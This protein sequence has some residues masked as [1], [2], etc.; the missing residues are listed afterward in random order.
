MRKSTLL[1]A[2][3]AALVLFLSFSFMQAYSANVRLNAGDNQLKIK[4]NTYQD[5]NLTYQFSGFN[6]VDI[7]TEKGI[8]TRLTVPAYAKRGEFGSPELP[9]KS[10]LIEIPFNASVKITL[11]NV[12]MKEYSL[13]ELGLIHPVF[14]FQPPVP[15]TGQ[16]VPFVYNDAA[17]KVNSFGTSQPVSVEVL[18]IMRGVRIGRLDISPVQ[19]NPA[20]RTI[21]VYESMDVEISFE[22]ADIAKTLAQKHTYANFLFNPVY[23]SLINYKTEEN[24]GRDA[25]S[26]YPI[27]YVIISDRMFEAQLQPLIEWKIRKGFTVVEAYTDEPNVGTTS[28]QI[29]SFLQDMYDNATPDDPAPSYVLFV[30]DIAQVPTFTGNAAGHVTD[31]YYCEYTGDYFPEVYYGRFSAQTTAQLQPQIDKTLMYEEY[32]MPD[33]SYLNEVVM[34]AG[35][36]PTYGPVHGNGQINYGTENYFNETFGLNSHTYL[37]P[38]SGSNAEN[39]HQDISNGVGFANYTAHGS[40]SGWA[41]PEFSV[42]DIPALQ[43][44]GK[45]GLLIGNCCSTSEYQVD[46]CFGEAIVRAANKGAIAYIGASNSTYWDEDYYFGV[47]VGA[48]SGTPPSYEETSLGDYDRAF[49]SHGEAYDDWYTTT[50]QIIY[51]GNLAVTEGSPGSAE[52]YWEAYN[53]MGDPSVMVYY[54]EPSAMDVSYNPLLPLGSATLTVN[55]APHAYVAVSRDGL[56]LG[57]ALADSMGVAIVPIIEGVQPGNAEVVATAQNKQPFTGTILIANPEGPFVMLNSFQFSDA[58][59]NNNGLVENGETVTVNSELK[60]WGSAEATSVTATLSSDDEFVTL[61]DA[62]EEYGNIAA[63]DSLMM[64]NAFEFQVAD[65]VPDQHIVHFNMDISDL[66]RQSWTAGFDVTLNAP[67]L[68]IV[69]MSIV[70]T[71]KGNSNYRLDPGEVADLV[72]VIRNSGHC[73]AYNA[74]ANLT[75]NSSDLVVNT[76]EVQIDTM[77]TEGDLTA[78]FN[79][80]IN[81]DVAIGTAIPLDFSLAAGPYTDQKMFVP[82][83]GLVVED[84]ETGDFAAYQWIQSGDSS[85]QITDQDV[86]EGNYSARSGDVSDNQESDLSLDMNVMTD[87]SISF[88]R[89]VSSEDDPNGEGYDYLGFLI[90]DN[91][92]Q[93]WD[94]ELGWSRVAFPVSAGEHT[95]KWIYSK[96]YSVSSGEDCAWIDFIVFPAVSSTVSVPENGTK[97]NLTFNVY[98]NPAA[99]NMTVSV[100][101]VESAPLSVSVFDIMGKEVIKAVSGQIMQAGQ[102]NINMNAENLNAGIYFLSLKAGEQMITRKLIITR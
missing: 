51:A 38:E 3:S 28:S 18:G 36:D 37:Y 11:T 40:P 87:D 50:D 6:T 63:E 83:V 31:L 96:D 71:A 69:S 1:K 29:K 93:R 55:A 80:T 44:D 4:D 65:L 72:L 32:T 26:T 25:N 94:G 82:Q 27:K 102:H 92:M 5:L 98:P 73:D 81:Q 56:C 15:K 23:H 7:K 34:I 57:A 30:G 21:R 97:S 101:M 64:E 22:N 52:Y 42:S 62:S 78:V 39:I 8:F 17:Y 19:Y 48:I 89:K 49:H 67:S 53:L 59:G 60:N 100:N 35:M 14:P 91:E 88:Y 45:Y 12:K 76:A 10:E 54:S 58:G 20:S 16:A 43:N 2:F 70:D 86:Y 68:K 75:T 66:T 99:G 95:F 24:A 77:G 13:D 61:T 74:L 85:W 33:P 79:V 84:F 47:G 90:D 46:E 9:V 41:D